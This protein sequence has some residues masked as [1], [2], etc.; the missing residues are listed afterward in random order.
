VLYEIRGK[1][2]AHVAKVREDARRK[3]AELDAKEADAEANIALSYALD[4]ID[5]ATSAIEEAEYAALDALDARARAV[6]LTS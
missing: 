6:A 2:Q 4:A 1:W 5:F 3:G